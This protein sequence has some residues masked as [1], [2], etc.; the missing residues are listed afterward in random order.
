MVMKS[1]KSSITS[2]S[3]DK[4]VQDIFVSKHINKN[5]YISKDNLYNYD[6]GFNYAIKL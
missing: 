4:R 3:S 5:L 2:N 6:R 1:Y